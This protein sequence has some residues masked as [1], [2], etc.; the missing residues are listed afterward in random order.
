MGSL[1]I[2]HIYIWYFRDSKGLSFSFQPKTLPK[3]TIILTSTTLYDFCPF[4]NF[5]YVESYSVFSF[6]AL[7]SLLNTISESVTHVITL[8]KIH[9]LLHSLSWHL[10]IIIY[11]FIHCGQTF[12]LMHIL[13]HH[14][15]NKCHVPVLSPAESFRGGERPCI[16]ESAKCNLNKIYAINI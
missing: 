6:K 1:I 11:F 5:I 8:V 14:G 4:F 3:L 15:E 2:F 16:A 13:I 12:G 10:Y 9:F 7:T